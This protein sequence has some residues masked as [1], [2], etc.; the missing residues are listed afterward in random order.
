M[1]LLIGV[2]VAQ[3]GFRRFVPLLALA[4]PPAAAAQSAVLSPAYEAVVRRYISGDREGAVSD[5]SAWPEESLRREV[6]AL[7]AFRK[8]ARACHPCAAS[9]A[10]Q[11]IPARAALL[12]HSDCALRARRHGRPPSSTS[13]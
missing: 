9:M 8:K 4:L 3:R 6:T 12:L 11:Q 1:N 5:L 13:R 10:W 7:S 2:S